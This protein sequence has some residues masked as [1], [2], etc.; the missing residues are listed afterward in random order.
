MGR[1]AC[2]DQKPKA[3]SQIGDEDRIVFEGEMK[4]E[5]INPSFR[6]LNALSPGTWD[7]C[8]RASLKVSPAPIRKRRI[9]C[10]DD[11]IA[12]TT[13]RGEILKGHGYSVVLYH[14]PLA[15]L[16]CDL[17]AFDLALLDFQMPEL[18]GRELLLRLRALGARFPI[19]LLTGDIAALSFEDRVLF[20]R[21]IDKGMPIQ[22]LLETIEEFLDPNQLP[23]F[24]V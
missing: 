18:N 4:K 10:V 21:C 9:L 2:R 7:G 6:P 11:E 1:A 22:Y 3:R 24:S 16:S 13:M 17:S 20:A 14:C 5:H 12:G 15:A 23:D 8:N 19:V